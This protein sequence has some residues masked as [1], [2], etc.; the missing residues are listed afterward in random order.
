M[1]HA[2][3]TR[4]GCG[5]RYPHVTSRKILTR[6]NRDQNLPSLKLFSIHV[7]VLWVSN[8]SLAD[9]WLHAFWW[10]HLVLFD[11]S[12][13]WEMGRRAPVSCLIDFV[14]EQFGPLPAPVSEMVNKSSSL[15]CDRSWKSSKL[16]GKILC[17]TKF[18]RNV[19]CIML[20]GFH[21][22]SCTG[23]QHSSLNRDCTQ[24]KNFFLHILAARRQLLPASELSWTEKAT[25]HRPYSSF[26]RIF[27]T[28]VVKFP[29]IWALV[30]SE[31]LCMEGCSRFGCRVN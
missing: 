13:N 20:L 30:S 12:T 19:W 2:N 10:Q 23:T 29:T 1:L 7:N 21:C 22:S 3:H 8:W 17:K 18:W 31:S 15:H 9:G 14:N 6:T 25:N 11:C 28:E 5:C 24:T 27:S 4:T 26:R 16:C